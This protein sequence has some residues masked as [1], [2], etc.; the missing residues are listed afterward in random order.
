M[1]HPPATYQGVWTLAS[2]SAT[3]S[4]RQAAHASG[5]ASNDSGCD[6]PRPS[7]IFVAL[8]RNQ[9]SVGHPENDPFWD[10]DDG[11]RYT[12]GVLSRPGQQRS[13]NLRPTS[14]MVRSVR[15]A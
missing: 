1:A 6:I 12:R 2:R 7:V 5:S 14:T 8:A 15:A 4:G 13:A 10:M 11:A 9:L 3:S